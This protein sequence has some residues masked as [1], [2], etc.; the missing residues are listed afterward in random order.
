MPSLL[1]FFVT[2]YKTGQ[3]GA[4]RAGHCDS[5]LVSEPNDRSHR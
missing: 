1:S 3:E 4:S 2:S 5:F